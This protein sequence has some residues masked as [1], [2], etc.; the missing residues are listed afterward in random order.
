VAAACEVTKPFNE[1]LQSPSGIQ[2]WCALDLVDSD[3]FRGQLWSSA[4]QSDCM[5]LINQPLIMGVN[6]S[7]FRFGLG[8]QGLTLNRT[9]RHWGSS[10]SDL[11]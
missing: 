1:K 7:R 4:A 6:N 8:I 5:D 2:A 10:F 9:T 11:V 3:G